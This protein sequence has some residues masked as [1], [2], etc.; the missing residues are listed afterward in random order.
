SGCRA[1]RDARHLLSRRIRPWPIA[2]SRRGRGYQHINQGGPGHRGPSNRNHARGVNMTDTRRATLE[3]FI[4]DIQQS[5]EELTEV[6]DMTNDDIEY[7]F[8]L[9]DQAI[10]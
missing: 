5:I 9:C 6:S 3:E 1:W 4:S 10:F 7:S 2:S 8:G